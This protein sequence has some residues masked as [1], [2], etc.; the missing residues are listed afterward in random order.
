MGTWGS[1]NFE[2]DGAL[3]FV[4]DVIKEFSDRIERL[5]EEEEAADI[6]EVGEAELV[7]MVRL[8][9]VI[10]GESGGVPPKRARVETWKRQYLRIYDDQIEELDTEGAFADERRAVIEHTFDELLKLCDR[11]K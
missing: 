3:D 1:G 8:I 9:T 6:D 5:F 7:P 2:N 10:C 4:G 11:F